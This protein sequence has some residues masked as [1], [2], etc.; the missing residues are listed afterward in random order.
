MYSPFSSL[1]PSKVEGG[2]FVT[3]I[4]VLRQLQQEETPL[5]CIEDYETWFNKYINDIKKGPK[6][7]V[8]P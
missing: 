4:T 1:K 5:I 7:G 2:L 6:G 3:G 8:V